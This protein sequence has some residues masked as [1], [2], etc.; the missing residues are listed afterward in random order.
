MRSAAHAERRAFEAS[1]DRRRR[2]YVWVLGL[3]A[4]QVLAHLVA[5][6]AVLRRDFVG[7]ERI[8]G[9]TLAQI[10]VAG[11]MVRSVLFALCALNFGRWLLALHRSVA[12][13]RRQEIPTGGELFLDFAI[14]IVNL[15]SP[16]VRTQ[17]TLRWIDEL[18]GRSPGRW[19]VVAWWGSFVLGAGLP[20][21][22]Y[23]TEVMSPL[24]RAQVNGVIW[25]ASATLALLFVIRVQRGFDSIE[26]P[27][28]RPQSF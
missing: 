20:P 9:L 12:I 4:A 26:A 23:I 27:E 3:L 17:R 28:P 2:L 5:M 1:E 19:L 16:V 14:P 6:A 10:E 21:A 25:L 15:I 7:D 22:Q 24:E 18:G 13:R 8:A 11:M